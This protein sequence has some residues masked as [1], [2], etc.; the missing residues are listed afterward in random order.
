MELPS[1][2]RGGRPFGSLSPWRPLGACPCE[3]LGAWE[4]GAVGPGMAQAN[5]S[6]RL[7]CLAS[8][9]RKL[10]GP[11]HLP[12]SLYPL[13]F[14]CL[15]IREAWASALCPASRDSLQERSLQ[16]FL[17]GSLPSVAQGAWSALPWCLTSLTVQAKT[18]LSKVCPTPPNT[19]VSL[20]V[21][22]V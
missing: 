17:S 10:R 19:G 7:A 4:G 14:C 6:R 13:M 9:Q 20:L 1:E 8:G 3:W 12:L 15:K 5:R 16:L 21:S 18:A 2:S 11:H 22:S